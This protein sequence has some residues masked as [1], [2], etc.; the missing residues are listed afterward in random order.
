MRWK[1]ILLIG[2][3]LIIALP[4]TAYVFVATYDYS[5]LKPRIAQLVEDATGRNLNLSGDVTLD[6]GF[7]P[8]L[9]VTDVTFANTSWGSQPEMIKIGKLQA[10][11]HLLPLLFRNV[12]LRQI[13]LTG[14]EVL[15]ETDPSGRGNW[16][17]TAGAGAG[18]RGRSFKPTQID[19]E[20]LRIENL[21]LTLR[22]AKTGSETRFSLI[23]FDVARQ[24]AADMLVLDLR[25]D[26]NGQPVMLSGKTGLIHGLLG[27]QRFPLELA[28]TFSNAT[29]RIDGAIDDVPSLDGIDL[30][31]RTSGTDLA[32]LDLG[33][34]IRLPKTDAFEAAGRLKGSR[35]A[36]T[37]KDLSAKFSGSG[38]DLAISGLVSDLIA[39]NGI[40]LQLKG[41]G[42]DLSEVGPLIGGK[43]PATDKFAL[44]GRLTGSTKALSLKEA[45]G[46]AGRGSLKL[47]L[48]GGIKNLIGLGGMNLKLTA[49]GKDLAEVGPIVG[50]KLPATGEFTFQGRLTGSTKALTLQ[51]AQGRVSRGGL[52]LTL[53][54]GIKDL[55]T[56]SGIDL[57][58]KGS[59]TDLAE[60]GPL[61]GGKFPATDEFAT[62]GRLTGSA[63]ALSLREVEGSVSRGS[64]NLTFN[65]GIE[66]L[67]DLEGISFK[68]KAMGK[69][70]AE[71][72]PLVGTKL[73]R[74]GPFDAS[75]RLSGTAKTVSLTE[76]SVIVGRSDFTG[77]AKIEFRKRPKVTLRL[78][79]SA[80]DFTPLM[81]TAE[82]DKRELGEEEKRER[83]LFPEDPLPFDA[84]KRVD[85]V[86]LIKA[87]NVHVRDAQLEFGHL[88]FTLEDSNLGIDKLEAT[89][90][91]TK[92]SGN[93]HIDSGS[94]P[95]VA[96]QFLT[97]NLD[98]GN[99]LKEASVSDQVRAVVDIAAHGKSSGDSIQ[100][101]M[102]NLDGSIGAVMGNGFFTKYLDLLGMN[103][104]EL[105]LPFWGRNQK[106]G[107][108]NC[109]AIQF[110][111]KRG[112][113]TNRAF[114]IDTQIGILTGEGNIDL[115][116]EQVNFLLDT[117]PKGFS[118]MNL[119]T[120][121]RVSGTLLNPHVRPDRFS[122]L[123][124]GFRFPGH[125][126]LGP[127]GLLAPFVRLGAHKKHP[128]DIQ[129]IGP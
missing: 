2:T 71:I 105:V 44:Q 34:G 46:S 38:V 62:H 10:Q 4:L 122:L 24:I 36:L 32:E 96:T 64:L 85:A 81:T 60:V 21:S 31:V 75:A 40:D 58:F 98:L 88:S 69:E 125:L 6:V 93:L 22:D 57:K 90:K 78:E 67:L 82:K 37:L 56:L 118:P 127:H 8:T 107:Q 103:L 123:T 79:S 89:Y 128:C 33:P 50:K 95:R 65:G 42:K 59:G 121:L 120:K 63:K 12:D 30:E 109:A 116:M 70:L 124:K 68:L 74:M 49:S 41:A 106:A 11:V 25:A 3:T 83:R 48:Q 92:I 7:L 110:D 23:S 28:G 17:L 13:S 47:S 18:M 55:T 52:R 73:P 100:S 102:A 97:Q 115:G 66:E 113:A 5:K 53:D 76:F 119:A 114:V 77:S 80:I 14:V 29:V 126:L 108:I 19:I 43:L 16:D 111:V 61:I 51:N 91:Q 84:L 99:L 112:V 35:L 26:Y 94:P 9:A 39:L 54:G 45:Q 15:L 86:I 101:L 129:S 117:K 27:H 104:S 1:W 20:N 72:G 87:R